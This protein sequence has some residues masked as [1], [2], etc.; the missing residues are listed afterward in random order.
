MYGS[1]LEYG[2]YLFTGLFVVGIPLWYILRVMKRGDRTRENY[3]RSK[4]L[5]L[6]EP[7]TLHPVVD[8]N[9]C[10]GTE[11]CVSACPEGEIIGFIN[12][13]ATLVSPT[14]CIGHGACATSC[15]VQAITLVFGTETRGV[16]LPEL[17][18]KFETNIK[19]IY[20][21]GELGGMG[22]IRNA[23][24]QGWEATKYIAESLPVRGEGTYDIAI[25]GAGPAGLSASLKA[26][27]I[28]LSH[29]C[30]EQ[31]DIGGTIL[32]YP[33]RKLVMTQP[34][35]IPLYGKVRKR[36]MLKEELLDL[37]SEIISRTGLSVNTMEKV[38]TISGEAG[39][40]M[41]GTTKG[42]YAAKRILL[43]IGRRGTPRK[44]GVVGEKSSK[45]AYRLIEPEQYKGSKVL[46][47]GGGDSAVE[48][49]LSI[50]EYV[51]DGV[52]LS[53]R[54]DSLSRVKDANRE[55]F[56]AAVTGGRIGSLF[57]SELKEIGEMEVILD[58]KGKQMAI[59]NNYV[60][61][62]IGGSLP[63]PFLR[64]VGINVKTKYG[65]A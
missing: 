63:A 59:E 19:G 53:Y 31:E 14:R 22:L 6:S 33:R 30:L 58:V 43:S 39:N 11:S 8:P 23:V 40:F 25:I 29:I 24:T 55:R 45:V 9:R 7:V 27:D 57:E 1:L 38:E 5:G 35:D 18:P 37:W 54:G 12:G 17:S 56:E 2:I 50:S 16:D 49:A 46:V 44:L 3:E 15:P 64:E 52:T 21:A 42:E 48:A 10:I 26:M 65:E 51:P 41:I 34:M 36:E 20:V 60:L 13:K 61:I 32:T 62:F 28:G 4:R 47:V